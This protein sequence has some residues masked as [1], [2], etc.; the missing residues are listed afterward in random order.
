MR[1]GIHEGSEDEFWDMEST[2]GEGQGRVAS[3]LLRSALDNSLQTTE[4][5]SMTMEAEIARRTEAEMA[6]CMEAEIERR[7]AVE[8]A[9]RVTV[10]Q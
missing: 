6:R 2:G 8:V 3:P 5:T 10:F 9:S 7:T 4:G 1:S